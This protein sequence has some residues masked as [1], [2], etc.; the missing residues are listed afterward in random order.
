V[1]DFIE[2]SSININY[3]VIGVA[4]VTYTVVTDT[5]GFSG[6]LYEQLT[7]GGVTFTG[8]VTSASITPITNTSWFEI[9]ATLVSTTN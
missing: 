7:M 6:K 2:C 8:Y 3:D 9:H 1:P 5:P 4:T